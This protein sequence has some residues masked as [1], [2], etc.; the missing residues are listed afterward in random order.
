M[1]RTRSLPDAVRRVRPSPGRGVGEKSLSHILCSEAD[2]RACAH[3][4]LRGEKVPVPVFVVPRERVCRQGWRQAASGFPLVPLPGIHVQ[5]LSKRA[6]S[7]G[8]VLVRQRVNPVDCGRLCGIQI[9]CANELINSRLVQ[10]IQH[11]VRE[12]TD[13][14]GAMMQAQ[15]LDHSKGWRGTLGR[16]G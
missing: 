4:T 14:H 8:G 1:R 2:C 15:L 9:L 10:H 13:G 16:R 11:I 5:D 7:F 6:F 3:I 12:S